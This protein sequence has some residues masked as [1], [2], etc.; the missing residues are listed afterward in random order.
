LMSCGYMM[1]AVRNVSTSIIQAL[2]HSIQSVIVD[3]CRSYIILLPVAW[4]LSRSGV[5]DRVFLAYPVA[6]SLSGII[7]LL[8]LWYFYR[9]DIK[10]M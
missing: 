8:L 7:A 9:R 2:G 4:L 10:V 6:D 1:I 3:L 5:V